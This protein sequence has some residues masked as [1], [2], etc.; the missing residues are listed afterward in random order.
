M[1][2][3]ECATE[4]TLKRNNTGDN[5]NDRFQA[6]RHTRVNLPNLVELTKEQSVIGQRPTKSGLCLTKILTDAR[7]DV[8][9]MLILKT[10]IL[11]M[12]KVFFEHT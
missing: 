5:S 4:V 11:Q 3:E 2:F 1:G 6:G 10:V 7:H 9:I 12:N 8:R